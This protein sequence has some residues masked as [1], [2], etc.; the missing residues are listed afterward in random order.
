L[1]EASFCI[2]SW[3]MHKDEEDFSSQAE[4]KIEKIIKGI[5]Y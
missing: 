5:Y 3:K 2:C 1:N 4:R